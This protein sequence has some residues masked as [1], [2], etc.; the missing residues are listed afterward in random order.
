[1]I[2]HHDMII[3]REVVVQGKGHMIPYTERGQ[4]RHTKGDL[5]GVP[6]TEM[7]SHT[8]LYIN[9]PIWGAE[10]PCYDKINP[11]SDFSLP[12]QELRERI[13]LHTV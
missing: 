12:G 7:Q 3:P 11:R 5:N 4:L 8:A 1:M 9:L 13:H 10:Y 6:R 2:M